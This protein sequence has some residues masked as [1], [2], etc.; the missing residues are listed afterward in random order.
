MKR[1]IYSKS[2]SERVAKYQLQTTLHKTSENGLSVTKRGLNKDALGHV[3]NMRRSFIA[4]GDLIRSTRIRYANV[5]SYNKVEVEF[6]YIK[7]I[8]LYDLLR[9]HWNESNI[10]AFKSL[11]DSY[12]NLLFDSFLVTKFKIPDI[13]SEFSNYFGS[14]GRYELAHRPAFDGESNIDLIPSN[15]IRSDEMDV[16]IDYEWVLNFPV[17]IEFVLY[18]GVK[19]LDWLPSEAINNIYKDFKIDKLIPVFEKMEESFIRG[20]VVSDESFAYY[21]SHYQ[22]KR[23]SLIGEVKEHENVKSKLENVRHELDLAYHSR[24]WRYADYLVKGCRDFKTNLNNYLLYSKK[25]ISTRIRKSLLDKVDIGRNFFGNTIS[26]EGEINQTSPR[27][28]IFSHYDKHGVIH[29]YVVEYLKGLKRLGVNIVFVST[30]PKLS[31]IENIENLC[32]VIVQRENIGYD[33]GSWK[34]GLELAKDLLLK[35]HSVILCNDSVYAPMVDFR[36]MFEKM[37]SDDCDFWGI[38]DNKERG[39]HLQSYF[40]VFNRKAFTSKVFENFWTNLKVYNRKNNIINK[41]EVRLQLLLVEDGLLPSSYCSYKVLQ[42]DSNIT[43]HCWEDLIVK[44]M[45]P[46]MK[47]ELLRDNPEDIDISNW[48]DI[49]NHKTTYDVKHIEQHL[50]SFKEDFTQ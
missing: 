16:V 38:T 40:M 33:F 50:L 8:S 35:F 34:I 43:H 18:R 4:A 49:V 3:H 27:L 28:C 9:K 14:V 5:E 26:I 42:S 17:P 47:I 44:H 36:Y 29:N 46:I 25:F 24:R 6:E 11:L 13:N 1:V 10:D 7:G 22:K 19:S 39:D 32:D 30:S 15:I 31:N 41:Y 23:C 12:R 37:E 20:V 45:C 21:F 2:T 48:R